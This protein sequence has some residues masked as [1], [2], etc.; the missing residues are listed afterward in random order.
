MNWKMKCAV[1]LVGM[2][3]V[4]WAGEAFDIARVWPHVETE[5]YEARAARVERSVYT[6]NVASHSVSWNSREWTWK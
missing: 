3:V 4:G 5:L 2:I 6:T 1:I